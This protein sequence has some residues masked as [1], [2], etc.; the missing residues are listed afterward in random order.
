MSEID[1][2]TPQ[3]P[4]PAAPDSAAEPVSPTAPTGPAPP[5]ARR[6]PPLQAKIA[7]G[8]ALAIVLSFFLCPRAK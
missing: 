1:D 6:G 8:L 5:T 4:S 3:P 2:S 7:G